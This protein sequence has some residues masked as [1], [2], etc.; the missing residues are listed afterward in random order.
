MKYS[1]KRLLGGRNEEKSN[2]WA[3]QSEGRHPTFTLHFLY[4]KLREWIK[5]AYGNLPPIVYYITKQFRTQPITLKPDFWFVDLGNSSSHKNKCFIWYLIL[6]ISLSVYIYIIQCLNV[7]K[8]TYTNI[9][10]VNIYNWTMPQ[11]VL[12][13]QWI[14]D[15]YHFCDKGSPM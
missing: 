3:D 11:H 10:Y 8:Y 6:R 5:D 9:I 4:L 15:Q 1:L 13:S 2:K 12:N 14:P 7:Y